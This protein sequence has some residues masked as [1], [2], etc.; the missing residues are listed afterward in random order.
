MCI[1]HFSCNNKHKRTLKIGTAVT[2]AFFHIY[3]KINC[4][5]SAFHCQLLFITVSK[6]PFVWFIF[7]VF[8]IYRFMNDILSSKRYC[9]ILFNFEAK[10]CFGE[11]KYIIQNLKCEKADI[12][13]CISLNFLKKYLKSLIVLSSNT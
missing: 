13:H 10:T 3:R 11:F 4:I 6:N 1:A 9:K 2:K 8:S 12:K 7:F 5:S